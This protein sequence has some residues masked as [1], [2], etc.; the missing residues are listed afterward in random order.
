MFTHTQYTHTYA[1][2][3]QTQ[4]SGG[5]GV[6]SRNVDI[7]VQTMLQKG[8][9]EKTLPTVGQFVGHV[10]LR[11]KQTFCQMSG[12]F[13]DANREESEIIK[14]SISKTHQVRD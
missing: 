8:A 7:E 2:T 14:H 10:F 9:I 6:E 13:S 12:P 3:R 5:G 4:S 1:R 11:P